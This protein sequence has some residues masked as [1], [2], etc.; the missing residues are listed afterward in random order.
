MT[1]IFFSFSHSF[2][3]CFVYIFHSFTR[4]NA[5]FVG[6]VTK[7]SKVSSKVIKSVHRRDFQP[8][9]FIKIQSSKY[10]YTH[11]ISLQS[12]LYLFVSHILFV[13]RRKNKKIVSLLDIY[14]IKRFTYVSS[15]SFCSLNH[16]RI[17]PDL[18]LQIT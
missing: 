11:L 10:F 14:P 7:Y 8:Y 1:S 16:F 13:S 3:S 9:G 4:F 2:L 6:L 5:I 18:Y 15:H 12:Y 17:F